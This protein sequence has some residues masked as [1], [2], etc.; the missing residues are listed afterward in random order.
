MSRLLREE[1]RLSEFTEETARRLT[2]SRFV[3]RALKG[4][5]AATAAISVGSFVGVKKAFAET[6]D[7]Y[8]PGPWCTNCPYNGCPSGCAPW[9]TSA[10]GGVYDTGYWVACS[11]L[12]YSGN[13]YKLCWDCYCNGNCNNTC[14]C[15][16][17][18]ICCNCYSPAELKAEQARVMALVRR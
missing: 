8:P 18:C 6:C 12:G 5:T 10:C 16:S 7:C 14:G 3:R 17:N 13:G 4:A 11:G 9:T 2:R 1:E 15:L